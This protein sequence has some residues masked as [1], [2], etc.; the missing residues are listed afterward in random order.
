MSEKKDDNQP[1]EAKVATDNKS[2]G[3]QPPKGKPSYPF[4][5]KTQGKQLIPGKTKFQG[6]EKGLEGHIFIF[7]PGMA[8]KWLL[9]REAILDHVG[10]IFSMSESIS[11]ED[12]QVTIVGYAKP[13]DWA[14]KAVFDKIPYWEQEEWRLD[15]RKYMDAKALITKNLSSC[16]KLIWGQCTHVLQNKIKM[17]PDWAAA[18]STQ[19]TLK[20]WAIISKIC[21]RV[22]TIDDY[23]T[24]M[25]E[26]V[27]AVIEIPNVRGRNIHDYYDMF[28]ER[29]KAA[30]VCG[31][32][33][34]TPDFKAH[35]LAERLKTCSGPTDKRYLDYSLEIKKHANE[36]FNALLFI[37]QAGDKYEECRRDLKNDFLK[38]ANHYPTTVDEAYHLLQN[39]ETAKAQPKPNP[40]DNT[41]NSQGN[42]RTT[43]NG[44]SYHQKA[45]FR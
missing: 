35:L 17:D 37:R 38:G 4:K 30:S 42:D 3:H 5:K 7:G 6:K 8:A 12:G 24:R 22:D 41:R 43:Q 31:V 44:H 9:T 10:R 2:S 29:V 36:Q 26:S 14:D 27:M 45:D 34:C 21:N 18:R 16:F 40:A 25:V 39:F 32:D 20:L 23:G 13:K 11:L 33:F 19:S 28:N 15:Y 1:K